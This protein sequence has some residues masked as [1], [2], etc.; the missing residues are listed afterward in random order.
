MKGPGI[1]RREFM[2]AGTGVLSAGLMLAGAAGK[3]AGQQGGAEEYPVKCIR[4]PGGR[5]RTPAGLYR[6]APMAGFMRLPATRARR[7]AS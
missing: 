6:W 7:A 3:A 2:Q 5:I 4:S 1:G